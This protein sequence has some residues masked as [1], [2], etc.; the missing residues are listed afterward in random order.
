[1]KQIMLPERQNQ[2]VEKLK[3]LG[4]SSVDF[5]F[6]PT[7]PDHF[8]LY[9][10]LQEPYFFALTK[11]GKYKYAPASDGRIST[12][13]QYTNWAQGLKRMEDWLRIL[14]RNIE[15]GNPWELVQKDAGS[16]IINDSE[17]PFSGREQEELSQK[18]DRILAILEQHG[19]ALEHVQEDIEYLKT[20]GKRISKKDMGLMIGGNILGWILTSAIPPAAVPAII[21]EIGQIVGGGVHRLQ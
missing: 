8:E 19:V 9:Y 17:E 15:V 7:G 16:G 20:S 2:I 21:N 13:G 5:S 14:K 6:T 12:E 11:E 3:D 1:M 10:K 4:F 18:L